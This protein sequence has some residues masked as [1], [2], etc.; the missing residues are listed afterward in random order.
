MAVHGLTCEVAHTAKG[1]ESAC[2]RC[3][4]LA[5]AFMLIRLLVL[6]SP[7]RCP[8]RQSIQQAKSSSPKCYLQ[9]CDKLYICVHTRVRN[10]LNRLSARSSIPVNRAAK[11]FRFSRNRISR[12]KFNFFSED[13]FH[14]QAP[15]M[16]AK[17][18][19]NQEAAAQEQCR[20][21]RARN[22]IRFGVRL[23]A[24]IL[25][26][27]NQKESE[28]DFDRLVAD[29]LLKSIANAC[30]KNHDAGSASNNV[31]VVNDLD[32]AADRQKLVNHTLLVGGE[33][34]PMGPVSE[35]INV[36]EIEQVQT[37]V[38]HIKRPLVNRSHPTTPSPHQRLRLPWGR[39]GRAKFHLSRFLRDL[40]ALAS[41]RAFVS[42][43]VVTCNF[44]DI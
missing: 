40:G 6:P 10:E 23:C 33:Y 44:C 11:Y 18:E 24:A 28:A 27:D 35:C 9:G 19:L 1:A 29:P 15:L 16:A 43:V 38:S 30:S 4:L 32:A 7:M 42:R 22:L 41:M 39:S 8:N 5:A 21:M 12:C 17:L 3:Y 31:Q 14:S 36:D 20:R 2:Y 37:S 26:Y 13:V 25:S 34:R